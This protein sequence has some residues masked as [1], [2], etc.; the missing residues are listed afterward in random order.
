MGGI[1]SDKDTI[2]ILSVYGELLT[3]EQ[4]VPNALLE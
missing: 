3:S 1:P 2:I 4:N